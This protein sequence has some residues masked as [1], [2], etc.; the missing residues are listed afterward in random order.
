MALFCSF[1]SKIIAIFAIPVI[2]A[3]H[4]VMNI[5]IS[6]KSQYISVNDLLSWLNVDLYF[7]P[8]IFKLQWANIFFH[9]L[10]RKKILFPPHLCPLPPGERNYWNRLTRLN[11][12][13]WQTANPLSSQKA[14][15]GLIPPSPPEGEGWDEGEIFPPLVFLIQEPQSFFK[16]RTGFF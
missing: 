13:V 11:G 16:N 9:H 1:I 12:P 8:N 4:A 15:L 5:A 6:I 14:F 10:N 3:A 2:K 7:S